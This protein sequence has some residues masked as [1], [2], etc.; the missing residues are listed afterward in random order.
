MA[1]LTL[2]AR[3]L[4]ARSALASV[5]NMIV[6]SMG[7]P[8]GSV[9]IGSQ[10]L[11]DVINA[12]A[13]A[14]LE[15]ARDCAPSGVIFSAVSLRATGVPAEGG[16]ASTYTIP[17]GT[18]IVAFS[19]GRD[20]ERD[21]AGFSAGSHGTA[22]DTNLVN[23]HESPFGDFMATKLTIQRRMFQPDAYDAGFDA[24]VLAKLAIRYNTKGESDT[25]KPLGMPLMFA[26]AVDAAGNQVG[27]GFAGQRELTQPIFWAGSDAKVGKKLAIVL[28]VVENVVFTIKSATPP[29]DLAWDAWVMLEG[30]AEMPLSPELA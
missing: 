13:G 9:A 10:S 14:A 3:K 16:G 4:Q 30:D 2:G 25:G 24:A 23:K 11:P 12:V 29:T 18:K 5:Q 17:K 7:R 20:E 21:L 6:A 1:N 19:Y 26:S 27:A 22:A 8:D 15:D 28:E